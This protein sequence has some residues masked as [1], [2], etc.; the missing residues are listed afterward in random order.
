MSNRWTP[1]VHWW[2]GMHLQ[3]QPFQ[4]F[5]RQVMGRLDDIRRAWGPARWGVQELEV[6]L[7]QERVAV[8][9]AQIVLPSGTAV[10]VPGNC[11]LEARSLGELV[12]RAGGRLDVRLGVP[13]QVDGRPL[14]AGPENPTGRYRLGA[15]TFR[16]KD[17]NTMDED[18]VAALEFRFLNGR[19]FL[20]TEDTSGYET[21]KIAEIVRKS[22]H[23]PELRV[24]PEYIPPLV[25]I[26]ASSRLAEKLSTLCHR[27]R[28]VNLALA[29]DVASR[30]HS[31]ALETGTDPE[32][33]F[34]L[35]ATNTQLPN[36]EQLCRAAGVHPFDAYRALCGLAG[37]LAIFSVKRCCPECP[38]YD[39]EA[40]GPCFDWVADRVEEY[41][42]ATWTRSWDCLAFEPV[43]TRRRQCMLPRE[44]LEPG[45]HLYLGVACDETRVNALEQ[46]LDEG[47]IK[48]VGAA[49]VG[50]LEHATIPG[51]ALVRCRAT[52]GRLP[53]LSD[54]VYFSLDRSSTDPHLLKGME[55]S[56][57][58]CLL[59]EGPDLAGL[60][61]GLYMTNGA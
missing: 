15:G 48:L 50:T 61:F 46:H 10:D 19:L 23:D 41:L 1:E 25:H 47:A 60:D 17:E 21:I 45:H 33:I 4:V 27:L 57:A 9:S 20:G 11:V 14:L 40:L 39:H 52:P 22:R 12:E 35:A 36:V 59:S 8:R 29:R 16:V 2:N 28:E 26:A 55:E 24:S 3:P 49:N 54:V 43:S 13:H 51:L 53:T 34:K 56:G 31:L 7:S 44:W 5:G 37:A 32:V 30:Q 38:A 6:E 18:S 42:D 58:L